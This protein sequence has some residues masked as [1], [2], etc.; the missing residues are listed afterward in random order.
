MKW[1]EMIEKMK[2]MEN[3]VSTLEAAA[4][5]PYQ[6]HLCPC[7]LFS[8]IIQLEIHNKMVLTS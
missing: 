6:M 8:G 7:N 3:K 5:L 1:K 4:D 2:Y